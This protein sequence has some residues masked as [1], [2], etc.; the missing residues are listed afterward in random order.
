MNEEQAVKQAR[1]QGQDLAW[2]VWTWALWAVIGIF[3]SFIGTVLCAGV[4]TVLTADG[5]AL[6]LTL[7][8]VAAVYQRAVLVGGGLAALVVVGSFFVSPPP[9]QPDESKG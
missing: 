6:G 3:A 5:T 9:D 7:Q 2:W 4:L 8:L 1:T